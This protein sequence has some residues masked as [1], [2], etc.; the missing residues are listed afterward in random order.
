MNKFEEYPFESHFFEVSGGFRYHYL[1]ERRPRNL[2][3]RGVLLM[4]H[5]NPT[6]SYMW[7]RLIT[8]F[9]DRYRCVA[10]D[11]IGC[12]LSD[13]PSESSYQ[14][15]LERRTDDLV[16]FIVGRDL[17]NI[18]L[19]GHDWGGAIGMGAAVK[20]PERFDRFILMNTAA[21][22]SFNCPLR[23]RFCR[24]PFL[25]RF[26]VQGM[27][28]FSSAAVR[29]A[30]RNHLPAAIRKAFLAPYDSWAN[31][32]AVYKF[33][34]DIPLS[35]TQPSYDMLSKIEESLPNFR[36][37]RMCFIWGMLDWCFSPEFLKRFLQFFPDANVHRLD[38]AHHLLLEDAPDDVLSA[39]EE[40]LRRS[41]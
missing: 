8:R 41:N 31:R 38:N 21:F 30:S 19:V 29:M 10:V 25:G 33:V 32:I 12:G 24:L 23:I 4:V 28:L 1:D 14:Y 20:L 26:L 16:R 7:R 3:Y 34:Q 11:H 37:K 36:F 40:F 17:R 27:N 9:R 6:W 39:I 13:K 35:V 5:G 22:K 2:D 18:T 15:T